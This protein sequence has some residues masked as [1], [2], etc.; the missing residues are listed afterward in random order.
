MIY[1]FIRHTAEFL[2]VKCHRLGQMFLMVEDW[3]YGKQVKDTLK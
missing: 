2:A 3:A 1:K